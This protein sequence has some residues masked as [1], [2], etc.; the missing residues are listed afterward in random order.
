[1]LTGPGLMAEPFAD[2][3]L[4]WLDEF[5]VL[6]AALEVLHTH[7]EDAAVGAVLF[8]GPVLRLLDGWEFWEEWC[9]GDGADDDHRL[10]PF[11]GED[12][13]HRLRYALWGVR[14]GEDGW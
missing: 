12:R 14:P 13:V 4:E 11:L 9:G 3:V 7:G 5:E 10:V 6:I 8:S 1:M 2:F